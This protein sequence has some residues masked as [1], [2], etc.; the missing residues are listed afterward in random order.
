[1]RHFNVCSRSDYID[2]RDGKRKFK[3]LLAGHMRVTDVGGHYLVLNHQPNVQFE[4]FEQ[5]IE[6]SKDQAVDVTNDNDREDPD[7]H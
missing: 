4:L 2:Q 7:V 6:P 5:R 3:W 1:M